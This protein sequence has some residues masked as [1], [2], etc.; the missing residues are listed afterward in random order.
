MTEER[1]TGRTTAQLEA[2]LDYVVTHTDGAIYVV[3][4][5]RAA[6]Y[7]KGLL[8]HLAYKRGQRWLV[9]RVQMVLPE[10]ARRLRGEVRCVFYDHAV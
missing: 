4:T 5:P 10:Q 9:D 2:V 8:H 1:Q 7:T 3:P 6:G